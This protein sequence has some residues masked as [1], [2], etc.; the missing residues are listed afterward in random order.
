MQHISVL[1]NAFCLAL[2]RFTCCVHVTITHVN[3]LFP[4]SAAIC[5]FS[6]THKQLRF[7]AMHYKQ[8][9][10]FAVH[11]NNNVSFVYRSRKDSKRCRLENLVFCIRYF[12]KTKINP[13]KKTSEQCL[14]GK[15]N[16]T[17][18]YFAIFDHFQNSRKIKGTFLP[19]AFQLFSHNVAFRIEL[20]LELTLELRR[21]V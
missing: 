20:K 18:Q 6:F 16:S 2:D 5:Y 21:M 9:C 15:T 8:F 19:T 3:N 11:Q 1:F 10:L 13:A 12:S 4:D 17:C 7:C 14:L